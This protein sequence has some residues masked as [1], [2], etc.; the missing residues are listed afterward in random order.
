M[1]EIPEHILWSND[2]DIQTVMLEAEIQNLCFK[3][4]H[5]FVSVS[6]TPHVYF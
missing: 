2:L 6:Y 5:R 4:E 3:S 1:S